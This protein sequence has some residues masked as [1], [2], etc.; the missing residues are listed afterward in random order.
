MQKSLEIE[1]QFFKYA[2]DDLS[3]KV[4][5]RSHGNYTKH[6][7]SFKRIENTEVFFRKEIS[8]RNK[9]TV[10][11]IGCG[12]GYHVCVFNTNK[13]VQEKAS[14]IGIDISPMKI[15]IASHLARALSF[16]NV[17]FRTGSAETLEFSDNSTDIVL[18]SDVVE[19]L[20]YPEKCFTDIFRIL[21]PGGVAI[22]TTPNA[23]YPLLKLKEYIRGKNTILTDKEEHI[24]LKGLKEWIRISKNSGFTVSD[25]RRGAL[26]F[27][28]YPYNR[29]PVLF[30]FIML[31]DQIL[32][33]LPFFKNW[34]EAI[35][36]KL[37]KSG[38]L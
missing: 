18:C 1:D 3:M 26:I 34:G 23:S 28:G 29:H 5:L 20:S 21:K 12:D 24:S 8:I 13:D 22:I 30:S 32:D 9:A 31:I 25:V 15:H 6:Y 33:R 11:D 19:H 36:L 27:G 14:F 10:L 2:V 37:S 17:S 38:N 16:E 35:T 4:R 7:E